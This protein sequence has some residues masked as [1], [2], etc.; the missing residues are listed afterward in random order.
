MRQLDEVLREGG[1][2]LVC[3][4]LSDV[5]YAQQTYIQLAHIKLNI[6]VHFVELIPVQSYCINRCVM[7]FLN[8][9]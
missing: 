8:S 4:Q 5:N 7:T 1:M 2:N 9:P 3:A 6:H